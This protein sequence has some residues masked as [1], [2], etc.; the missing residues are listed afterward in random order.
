M[1]LLLACVFLCA[2][3]AVLF[4]RGDAFT[5]HALQDAALADLQRALPEAL[6]GAPELPH[7]EKRSKVKHARLW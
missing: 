6:P 7:A 2:V 5:H 1:G 4:V 3:V